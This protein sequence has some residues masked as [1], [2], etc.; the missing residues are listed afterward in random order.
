MLIAVAVLLALGAYMSMPTGNPE[1][2]THHGSQA[3]Q[4]HA[5]PGWLTLDTSD[6][7]S[8]SYC[9]KYDY[10][11]NGYHF[12]YRFS[13]VKGNTHYHRYIRTPGL[14]TINRACALV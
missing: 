7:N 12:D 2:H 3:P 8:T 4:H 6:A 10:N 13:Y 14:V 11:R 1:D 9:P 5:L